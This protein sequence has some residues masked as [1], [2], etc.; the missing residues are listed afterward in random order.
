MMNNHKYNIAL[1]FA[2]EDRPAADE[3]AKAVT[4]LN[5]TVFY[6]EYEKANLWGKDLYEHLS[7][8]YKN[9][10]DFC[11]MFLSEHY[12]KKLWTNHERKSA[13]ARAFAENREYILPIRL[14]NTEIEGILPTVGYLRW[15]DETVTDI[16]QMIASKLGKPTSVNQKE[17]IIQ[18][19][20]HLKKRSGFTTK[21]EEIKKRSQ[22]HELDLEDVSHRLRRS[23]T[24]TIPDKLQLISISAETVTFGSTALASSHSGKQSFITLDHNFTE[25]FAPPVAIENFVGREEILEDISKISAQ[26]RFV[27]ITGISGFGKSSL[28]KQLASASDKEKTFWYEFIPGLISLEDLLLKLI[29]FIN[30]HSELNGETSTFA[31]SGFSFR[32]RIENL[33]DELNKKNYCLFFD[34]YEAAAGDDGINS[35]FLLLKK[36]LKKGLVFIASQEN[37]PIFTLIDD[38]SGLICNLHIEGLAVDETVD[39][40][41]S[42]GIDTNTETV[43]K[44]DEILGGMPLALN[45]LV[46]AVGEN[47]DEEKLLAQAKAVKD[48]I[49]E[50]LFEIVY[51][52]LES[53]ERELL[54]TA[55]LFSLPFTKQNLLSAHRTIFQNNAAGSFISLVRRNLILNFSANYF[56]LHKT[57]DSLALEMAEN[58]LKAARETIAEHFLETLP[59]DYNANLESL[60]LFAQAENYNRAVNVA[61]DLID[62]RFLIFDLEMAERILKK[63]EDKEI[64]PENRMWFLGDRGLVAHH[65]HRYEES[66]KFYEEMFSLAG[67]LENKRGE[68]L[69][70]HRLGALYWQ[71]KDFPRSVEFYRR[72][73]IIKIEIEDHEGQAQVHN[74][75][76]LIYTDQKDFPAALAEFETGLELRRK[77]ETPEWS[78]LPLY[79][80]LGILYA[81]QENW[82]KAFEYS[83]KA[84]KVSEDFDSPYDIAKSMYNL[85]KHESVRGDEENAREKFLQVLETAEKYGIAELE[86]LSCTALGRSYGDE[87]DYAKA[88]SYFER[89]AEI[90]ERYGD[91]SSLGRILFDI[92]TYH[93]L[94]DDKKSALNSYLEGVNL[95]EFLED[96]LVKS[97]LNNVCNLAGDFGDCAET[98]EIIGRLKHARRKFARHFNPT[99]KIAHLCDALSSIY[100]D[101]LSSERGAIAYLH[102]RI[103]V[104]E[105]LGEKGELAKAWL[106][107]GSVGEDLQKY[108]VALDANENALK[109]ITQE[110]LTDLLG[111]VFYNTGNIYAKITEYDKAEEFYR[112][113]EVEAIIANDNILLSKVHHNLGETFSRDGRPQEAVEILIKALEAAREQNEPLEIVFSLNSLGLSYEDLEQETEA[114]TCWHEAVDLSRKNELGREEA[115]TLIS[116]GNFYLKTGKFDSAKFYYEQS[117]EAA[118]R[119]GNIDMEEAAM[120]SLALSH[121]RLGSFSEIEEEFKGIAERADELNHH[122]HLIKFLAI[123]GSIN[124]DEGEIEKSVEM[125]EKAFLFAYWRILEFAAP[126]IES[127]AKIPINML[128][129]TFLLTHLEHSLQLAVENDKREVALTIYHKLI[130]SL[131]SREIWREHNFISDL[132]DDIRNDIFGG[133]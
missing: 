35:F 115:N 6:D 91:K 10:A 94:N 123:A 84:L 38:E 110:N 19:D 14:D 119:L 106:D 57:I 102:S 70:L 74:N 41:Q 1:S 64:S 4:E 25:E 59:D 126:F 51:Q 39:Y 50:E 105:Q 120:L 114:L 95:L 44:I 27:S 89:V 73:L 5:I 48:R 99:M 116:I 90:Y 86:E 92:G 22:I 3:L 8:I 76:G 78:Y 113:A 63:F 124:L 47:S 43:E 83:D 111:I 55:A 77:S 80:N 46:N 93:F 100:Q 40:F 98:R 131:N 72:S 45:L 127:G 109:I 118:T 68:A 65:L 81:K 103:N 112:R 130:D 24:T 20:E 104:I 67:E 121:R 37:L 61:S 36:R 85:G 101:V 21:R 69:A 18:F 108:K 97:D 117:L 88:I 32:E 33:I 29:R 75:L 16:A 42:K 62:R 23:E 54:T 132:L 9:S 87:G 122:E 133:S 66:A 60:L 129:L 15:Q 12:A 128:E 30:R 58:D 79:S 26:T 107:L 31:L 71:T 53:S 34:D 17:N 13:Q 11:V 52:N 125:F 96:S 28:L 49:V 82:D 2:G 7:D 56:Y